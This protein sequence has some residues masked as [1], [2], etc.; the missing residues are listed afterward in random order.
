MHD[1]STAILRCY[2][3]EAVAKSRKAC[4]NGNGGKGTKGKKGRKHR[5]EDGGKDEGGG[6]DGASSVARLETLSGSGL[7]DGSGKVDSTKG[8]VFSLADVSEE[9]LV[10]ELARRRAER[11][12]LSGANKAGVPKKDDVDPTGQVC[13]IDGSGGTITCRDLME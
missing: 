7:T 8:K 5:R 3:E 13:T 11:F 9:E 2:T 6:E 1:D 12:K 4:P 10:K